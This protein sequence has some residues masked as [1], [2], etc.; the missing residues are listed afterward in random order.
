MENIIIECSRAD[1]LDATSNASWTTNIPKGITINPGDA[2]TLRNCFINSSTSDAENIEI[3]E[4]ITVSLIVGYYD[5]NQDA[6]LT[7]LGVNGLD[8]DYYIAYNTNLGSVATLTS[9]TFRG[10]WDA[11]PADN[12]VEGLLTFKDVSGTVYNLNWG[13][14]GDQ[15]ANQP[16]VFYP[17]PPTG[18]HSSVTINLNYPNVVVSSLKGFAQNDAT[19]QGVT[20]AGMGQYGLSLNRGSVQIAIPAGEYTRT[21]IAKLIT[22]RLQFTSPMYGLEQIETTNDMMRRTDEGENHLGVESESVDFDYERTSVTLSESFFSEDDV[23]ATGLNY[24][25]EVTLEFTIFV[26]GEATSREEAV[27]TVASEGNGGI[28]VDTNSGE[29]VVN[30]TGNVFEIGETYGNAIIKIG[31]SQDN[32][33]F[34]RVGL[35]PNNPATKQ[36]Y[37]DVTGYYGS[38]ENVLT[39]DED[40]SV[41]SF[42]YLHMPYYGSNPPTI[43]IKQLQNTNSTNTEAYNKFYTVT[44]L[45]GVFFLDLQPASFWTSLGFDLS[46]LIVPV[47][48]NNSILRADL[49]N[50]ITY[51]YSSLASIIDIN[52]PK[53]VQTALTQDIATT[54]TVE[55]IGSSLDDVSTG[56][57]Y[58]VDMNFGNQKYMFQRG[59]KN[60]IQAI[61]SKYNQIRDFVTGY[62]DSSIGYEHTGVPF[63]LQT[64]N[65]NILDPE[66]KLPDTTIGPKS[67]IFIQ[68][69]KNPQPQQ[70]QEESKN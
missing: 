33:V 51:G 34:K 40:R 12:L 52:N 38:S 31:V 45:G 11:T 21:G 6:T 32:L 20:W 26:N 47:Q 24:D 39:Y 70:P 54:D 25:E 46:K 68:I 55:L 16:S 42:Q 2:I 59:N 28:I 63:D 69:T 60:N 19:Y 48:P 13:G 15:K 58:L 29:V 8:Y 4:D 17:K 41:F 62:S 7:S 18:N 64:I 49:Q 22:D 23:L 36:Y 57:F 1:S 10:L 5:V 65:V 56:G 67:T 35:D 3:P 44:Q 43:C 30:F 27:V 50:R 14:Y 37:Y 66:T 9:V 61:V 53:E